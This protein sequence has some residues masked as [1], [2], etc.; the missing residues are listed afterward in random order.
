PTRASSAPATT[1]TSNRATNNEARRNNDASNIVHPTLNR[2]KKNL[3]ARLTDREKKN[4]SVV[5]RI[6]HLEQCQKYMAS[7]QEIQ[8]RWNDQ[9]AKGK[10]L[11]KRMKDLEG[12]VQ[13]K[14][15]Q[16]EGW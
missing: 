13:E 15:A 9:E 3:Q 2:I 6:K 10:V 8:V 4:S 16:W 14:V 5:V 12:D 1:S 11:E 7:M